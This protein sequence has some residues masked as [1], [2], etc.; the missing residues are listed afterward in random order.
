MEVE[1]AMLEREG[2]PCCPDKNTVALD[3]LSELVHDRL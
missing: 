3:G 1:I 2:V